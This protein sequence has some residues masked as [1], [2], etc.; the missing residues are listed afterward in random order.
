VLYLNY[1]NEQARGDEMKEDR[2]NRNYNIGEIIAA[3]GRFH[4]D[5]YQVTRYVGKASIGLRRL[6]YNTVETGY[7]YNLI[8][9]E[10]NNFL[11]SEFVRRVLEKRYH[12]VVI[13]KL[14]DNQYGS[15][16]NGNSV[17]TFP[18]ND[19]LEAEYEKTRVE[20]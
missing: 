15:K 4:A 6:A 9:P 19:L 7:E 3:P 10:K 12:G 8:K 1:T 5:Y 17:M 16:W 20:M 14:G 18:A 11:G 13:S 2:I